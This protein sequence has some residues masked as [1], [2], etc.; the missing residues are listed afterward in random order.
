MQGLWPEAW[1]RLH[2]RERDDR[3]RAL[4]ASTRSPRAAAPAASSAPASVTLA[5]HPDLACC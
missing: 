2:A 1:L 4:A 3:A 5:A